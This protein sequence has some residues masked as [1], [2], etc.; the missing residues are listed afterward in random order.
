MMDQNRF[1]LFIYKLRL[2]NKLRIVQRDIIREPF[3]HQYFS[4]HLSKSHYALL[5]LRRHHRTCNHGE[6]LF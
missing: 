3:I 5:L 6:M 4:G 1:F 2:Q